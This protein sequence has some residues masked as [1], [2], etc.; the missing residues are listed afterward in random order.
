MTDKE[1]RNRA[2]TLENLQIWARQ[3]ANQFSIITV[4]NYNHYQDSKNEKGPTKGPAEGHKQE[5]KEV[6]NNIGRSSKKTD[7][8]PRV[9]EFLSFWKETFTQT[10]GQPYTFNYGKEGKLI[11]NLLQVHSLETLQD[12]A[13]QFFRDEQCKRRGL[14]I[15]IF[16]QEINRLLSLK[17]MNPLE[18]AR[19][20]MAE[21]RA[22]EAKQTPKTFQGSPVEEVKGILEEGGI[23]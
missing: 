23:E 22:I 5:C 8:D 16:H 2:N 20:E 12:T 3:R 14:T 7:A 9:K 11:K 6:K 1:I 18:E 21:R 4:C 15:G 19:R 10:T 17:G 13:R